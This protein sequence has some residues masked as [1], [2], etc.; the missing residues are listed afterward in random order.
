MSDFSADKRILIVDPDEERAENMAGLLK[1]SGLSC[2]VLPTHFKALAYLEEE[3]CALIIAAVDY[4]GIDGMEFCSIY[5]KRQCDRGLDPCYI[6]LSGQ[7]WQRN[8]ICQSDAPANDFLIHPCLE[9]EL[10]WRVRSGLRWIRQRDELKKIIYHDYDSGALNT[11]GLEKVL[12]EEVNRVGRKKG[13]LSLAVVDLKYFDWMEMAGNRDGVSRAR[14]LILGFLARALRNYDHLGQ[15]DQDRMCLI[16][17]DC[18]YQCFVGLL[19]R[20]QKVLKNL[21]LDIQGLEDLNLSFR[22]ELL[23]T[24]IDSTLG[25][26][27]LCF[28]HLRS[29]LENVTTLPENLRHRQAELNDKGLTVLSDTKD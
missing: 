10:M 11:L 5:S 12:R 19:D 2:L 25:G 18:D 6:I 4:T 23:S 14:R 24:V 8:R 13:W 26:S 1:N 3:S 22:G 9:C 15:M 21:D 16:S 29:W 27:E 17:G 28:R 20:M 7:S